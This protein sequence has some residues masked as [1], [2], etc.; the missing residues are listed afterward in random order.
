[1][2]VFGLDRDGQLTDTPPS[3]HVVI[4]KRRALLLSR[5]YG[6]I[7]QGPS[8]CSP[9][10]SRYNAVGLHGQGYCFPRV[11]EHE[12]FDS[13]RGM[14][15][16]TFHVPSNRKSMQPSLRASRAA[17]CQAAAPISINFHLHP[18]YCIAVVRHDLHSDATDPAVRI[19]TSLNA[20]PKRSCAWACSSF[21][22]PRV[23][24][25]FEAPVGI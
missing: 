11:S 7:A 10:A 17:T 13:L 8:G 1:M 19:D 22:D 18:Y 21:Q 16:N 5:C 25:K 15:A 23:P 14:P 3:L 2:C 12:C 20:A 24:F 6:V 4:V 9:C